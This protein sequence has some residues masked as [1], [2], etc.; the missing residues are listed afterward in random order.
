MLYLQCFFI[1]SNIVSINAYNSNPLHGHP[2]LM[3]YFVIFHLNSSFFLSQ[4]MSSNY[5]NMYTPKKPKL[6]YIN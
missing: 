2:M 4:K 1:K 3:R 5:S 6:Q